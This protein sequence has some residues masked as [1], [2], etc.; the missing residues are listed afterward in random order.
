M[1]III[2]AALAII[3]TCVGG[4][5]TTGT[6]GIVPIGP[7]MYMVGGLGAFTDFSGSGAKAKLFKEASTFCADKKR[8]MLP[9][10]STSKDSGYGTYASAEIQFYCLTPNDPRLAR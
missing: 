5:A 2:V 6:E 1:K 4:C 7:D 8:V 9:I 10:N 3:T